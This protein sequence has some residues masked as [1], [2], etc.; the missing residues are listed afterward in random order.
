MLRDEERRR[1]RRKEGWKR[2]SKKEGMNDKE[3]KVIKEKD[4]EEK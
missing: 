4:N 3:K 1:E 2:G